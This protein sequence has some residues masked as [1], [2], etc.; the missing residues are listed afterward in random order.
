M[1]QT[2]PIALSALVIIA[3]FASSTAAGQD[4]NAAPAKKFN[5]ASVKTLSQQDQDRILLILRSTKLIAPKDDLSV[6]DG[7]PTG[8]ILNDRGRA[9]CKSTC[10]AGAGSA[11][12]ACAEIMAAPAAIACYVAAGAADAY[13][14][15]RC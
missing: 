11:Q 14:K 3:S 9:L 4:D 10:D 6:L 12:G 8:D 5:S 13:C 15:D 2:L 1:K 7:I